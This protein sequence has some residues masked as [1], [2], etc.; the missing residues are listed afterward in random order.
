MFSKKIPPPPP[1]SPILNIWNPQQIKVNL[2]ISGMPYTYTDA[3]NIYSLLWKHPTQQLV[4]TTC[5]S[6][7]WQLQSRMFNK[8]VRT[9]WYMYMYQENLISRDIGTY[10][11]L[12]KLSHSVLSAKLTYKVYYLFVD[13]L[14][15]ILGTEPRVCH[16]SVF[17]QF[18][19]CLIS[20]TTGIQICLGVSWFL[21]WINIK[22]GMVQQITHVVKCNI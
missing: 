19:F 1:N 12:V 21:F 10:D 5:I 15:C 20:L 16:W 22:E 11:L 18:L 14:N 17:I 4:L 13:N 8:Q 2:S 9:S 6:S 3:I 7:H